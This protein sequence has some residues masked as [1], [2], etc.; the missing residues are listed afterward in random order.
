MLVPPSRKEAAVSIGAQV[1]GVGFLGGWLIAIIHGNCTNLELQ[2]SLQMGV[3]F[4]SVIIV[5]SIKWGWAHIGPAGAEQVKKRR[6][7]KR[8][9]KEINKQ[10]MD[11]NLS[12]QM[13][14]KLQ[15]RKDSI[16]IEMV[17]SHQ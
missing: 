6:V 1:T 17:D 16:A 7:L 4:F 2:N 8:K 14:Q 15:E 9:R 12:P 11:P 13:K 10:L 5:E 3:P